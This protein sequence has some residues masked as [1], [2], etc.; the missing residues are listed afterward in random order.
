MALL[1]QKTDPLHAIDILFNESDPRFLYLCNSLDQK[2]G[3][4]KIIPSNSSLRYYKGGYSISE[5]LTAIRN[6]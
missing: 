4:I 6:L 2:K 5:A 3:I 1:Q